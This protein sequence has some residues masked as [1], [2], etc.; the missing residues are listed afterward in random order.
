MKTWIAVFASFLTAV[1]WAG[2]RGLRDDESPA[3]RGPRDG[4]QAKR[5]RPEAQAQHVGGQPQHGDRPRDGDKRDRAQSRERQVYART[6]SGDLALREA[7][8]PVEDGRIWIQ[9]PGTPTIGEAFLNAYEATGAQVCL[10]AAMDAARILIRGQFLTGRWD[11]SVTTEPRGMAGGRPATVPSDRAGLR[12][13][14]L[15]DVC[16]ERQNAGPVHRREALIPAGRLTRKGAGAP[17]DCGRASPR[18]AGGTPKRSLSVSSEAPA[19]IQASTV[20]RVWP[21]HP[22]QPPFFVIRPAVPS[23]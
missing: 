15:P 20:K 7:E 2:G 10:H 11:Y 17:E 5:V 19:I 13:H 16:R 22:A 4:Y 6:S 14:P 23:G 8:G 1:A 21:C 9:P 12:R 3:Q 18:S